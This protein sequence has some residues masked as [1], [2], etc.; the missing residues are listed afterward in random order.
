MSTTYSRLAFPP[1][2]ERFRTCGKGFLSALEWSECQDISHFAIKSFVS[3]GLVR[4]V[5]GFAKER[6]IT[7]LASS[8]ASSALSASSTAQSSRSMKIGKPGAKER[9]SEAEIRSS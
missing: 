3:V 1:A 4:Y 6:T 2:N 8:V 5:G 9:E 7:L